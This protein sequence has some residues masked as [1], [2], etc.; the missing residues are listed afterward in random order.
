[1]LPQ[2]AVGLLIASIAVS[3]YGA[4][5]WKNKVNEMR[6]DSAR[7]VGVKLA[8]INDATKTY[9]TTFFTQIQRGQS[10]TRNGFTLPAERLLAPSLSDLSSLGFLPNRALSPA[11]YSGQS[12]GFNVQMR[13]DTQSGCTV[14]TCN[15]QF[16]VTTSAPLMMAG[17]NNVDVQRATLAANTASA[18]NAGV[19]IPASLGGDPNVFVANGGSP[20]GNNP[21]GVPGLISISNGYDSSGFM[22]FDRRDGS[23]PRTGDINMQDFAGDKHDINNAGDVNAEKVETLDRLTTGEFLQIN[24]VAT[25]GGNCTSNGLVAQNS[26]GLLFCNGGKWKS[27][28]GADRWGG[29]FWTAS[30][31]AGGCAAANPYTGA[32]SCPAG[33]NLNSQFAVAIGGCNPC[34]AYSC[35]KP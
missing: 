16:Q 13:V 22:E 24:G 10:V 18:G 8:T 14:P 35:Y 5:I 17:T 34:V 19:S 31:T 3:Y 25:E 6:N 27:L 21:G 33:Y 11:V 32:C 1:M 7:A 12:I 9:A 29:S 23:L 30:H 4:Q 2:L 20:V 28:S 15:L 26:K